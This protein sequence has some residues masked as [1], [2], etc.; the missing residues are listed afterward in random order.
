MNIEGQIVRFHLSPQGKTALKGLVS[1]SGSFQALVIESAEF[2]PLLVRRLSQQ[3]EQT[4][5]AFPVMLLR[6]DY[7]ATM[8]WDYHPETPPPRA[9]PG[10]MA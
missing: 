3:R 5:G 4:G 10:F 6:W 9:R 1:A 7:I 2:G 8:A